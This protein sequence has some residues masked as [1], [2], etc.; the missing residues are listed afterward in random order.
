MDTLDFLVTKGL[1]DATYRPVP[2]VAPI[3]V[4]QNGVIFQQKCHN[5]LP[6]DI[7]ISWL[8]K[9][10]R[11]GLTEQALY[12]AYHIAELGRIFRSHLC[13]RLITILSEDI[14]PAEPGLAVVIER[15]Y[16]AEKSKN[17]TTESDYDYSGIME[18]IGLLAASRKSRITDWLIHTEQ[19]RIDEIDEMDEMEGM[20]G[21]EEMIRR[22][23][24]LCRERIQSE[25]WVTVRY[26]TSDRLKCSTTKKLAVY[27]IWNMLLST[28]DDTLY[29]EVVALLRLFDIRGP[30]YGLLHLI[31]AITLVF[32]P[33]PKPTLPVPAST[34]SWNDVSKLDFPVLNDA[35]DMHTSYGRR[36]LGR[37]FVDFLHKGSQV[38][39]WTP[40]PGELDLIQRI[41]DKCQPGGETSVPR[42]YQKQIIQSTV[43]HLNMYRTGWLLMACGTGKTKTSY[44]SMHSIINKNG[45]KGVVVVVTPY[46]QI[47]RQFHSCWSAM[48]RLHKLKSITGILGGVT[49]SFDKDDYSNYEYLSTA[50]SIERFMDYPDDVKFIFTTYSSLPRVLQSGITPTL[51]VY[52]EAHHVKEHKMFG[53]GMEL[54]LTATPHAHYRSF[55]DVIANY[56]LRNAIN[57]GYL[58][59]YKVGIFE[60]CPDVAC[61]QFV[62]SQA[63]KTIVYC[64]TTALAKEYLDNWLICGGD[65]EHSFYIDGSTS[66]SERHR[67][68]DGFRQS[69]KA[70]I[71]NCSILGEGVDLPDCD[72]ILIHSGY[73]QP[74]RVVQAMGRPLRLSKGKSI[75]RIYI[76]GDGDRKVQARIKAMESYDPDVRK[77]ISYIYED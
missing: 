24:Y 77:H 13:N 42:E 54:F 60:D 37:G 55:G 44:W 63:C 47:L 34:L 72:S 11:R 67:V 45:G 1:L 5:G 32:L 22:A 18:M 62:Q 21:M 10:I 75:S 16:T 66:K 19:D 46:L 69:K 51:T 43:Q 12:C 17:K 30:S 48:N 70:V 26:S 73:I 2:P 33:M 74:G 29:D 68:F 65:P 3:K 40:F 4:V 31:H 6:Y 52:D 38:E 41:K 20:A 56:N 61:L 49:D 14:G 64:L 7:A 53:A 39:N 8:Q 25:E 27:H 71:F 9:A 23:I 50:K 28:V 35:V 76:I 15:L 59:P 36:L 58:T 57:D